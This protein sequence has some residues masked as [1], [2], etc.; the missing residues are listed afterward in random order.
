MSFELQV[1]RCMVKDVLEH[2]LDHEWTLQGFGMLRTYFGGDD[3]RMQV[4]H[5]DFEVLGNNSVHDHPWDFTSWILVGVIVN[6][7]FVT[8]HPQDRGQY[9]GLVKGSEVLIKPGTEGEL[10]SE[11]KT[12]TLLASEPEHL[13]EG[14]SYSQQASEL[15]RTDYLNGTVT[16]NLRRRTRTQDVARSIH[17]EG[18]PEWKLFLPRPAHSHEVERFC[19]TALERWHY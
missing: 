9:T 4:W 11:P 16:I 5:H 3:V 19:T 12:V 2:P 17:L 8:V 14:C 7:R 10:L 13:E 18:E 6:T 1:I 15:H